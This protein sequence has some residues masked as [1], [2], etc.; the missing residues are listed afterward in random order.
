MSTPSIYLLGDSI[1]IDYHD[2]FVG[3]LL[4]KA[5]VHRKDGMDEAK[6]NLDEPNGANAGTSAMVRRFISALV[7]QDE[8]DKVPHYDLFLL[9]C[10]LHDIKI[11]KETDIV[12]VTEA[13]YADNL[14]AIVAVAP[15][16]ADHFAWIRTTPIDDEKHGA[17]KFGF[18]RFEKDVQAYN[19]IADDIMAKHNIPVID[20]HGFTNAHIEVCSNH[21][22]ET[23]F[24]DGVHFRGPMKSLQGAYLAGWALH[25]LGR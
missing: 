18:H 6:L 7:E 1:S 23:I 13:E 14:E 4:G 16:L 5:T 9:N 15:K 17:R 2:S 24:R 3:S 21:W 8:Q 12:T 10:G 11:S 22:P 19:A 25:H 20:M